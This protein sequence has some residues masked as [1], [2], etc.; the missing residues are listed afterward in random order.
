MIIE[1]KLV[2]IM[3]KISYFLDTLKPS[4]IYKPTFRVNNR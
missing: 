3:G 1:Y 4:K 2:K